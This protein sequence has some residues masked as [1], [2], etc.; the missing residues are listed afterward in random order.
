VFAGWHVKEIH[1]ETCGI[2]N[3][4]TS[5]DGRGTTYVGY[6][7]I[8]GNSGL[9][10]SRYGLTTGSGQWAVEFSYGTVWGMAKCSETSGNSSSN[11]WPES[12]K[13]DW[14]KTPSDTTGQYCWCQATGFT[15]S[16]NSYTSGPQCTTTASSLWV[17]RAGTGSSANCENSCAHYC[18]SGGLSRAAFRAA[19]FGAVGQ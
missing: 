3:L 2:N 17:F 8:N 9:N 19:M 6:T 16:G 4:D 7:Q 18:A 5:T 11:S 15:A 13:S 1:P 12:S 14:L 10:G